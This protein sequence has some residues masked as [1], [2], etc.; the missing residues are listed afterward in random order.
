[1]AAGWS[2]V[3]EKRALRRAMRARREALASDE[4][5]RAAEAAAARLAG[6]AEFAAARVISG[7][8]PTR[9]EIDPAPALAMAAARGAT[10]V[11]PRV[12]ADRPRLRFHRITDPAS[13]RAGAFGILEPPADSPELALVEIDLVVVPGLAFDPRGRRLGYGSGYYDEAAALLRA[14][15]R[16]FLVGVG[17]D[18]QLLES[19]PAGD[20]DIHL[21]CV[22]TDARLVRS[23]DT[24]M[25]RPR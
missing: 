18:F 11:Y 19:C 25:N 20:G 9:G 4:R 7:Y 14:A 2:T 23:A 10:V 6:L 12:T 24:E 13:L 1:M 21:D 3:D 22:V 5:A 15:G 8:L 16:G 17:F